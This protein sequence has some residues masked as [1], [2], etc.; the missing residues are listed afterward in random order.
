MKIKFR[1]NNFEEQ[2]KPLEKIKKMEDIDEIKSMISDIVEK[3]PT[4]LN[5]INNL[6]LYLT[7]QCSDKDIQLDKIKYILEHDLIDFPDNF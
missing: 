2:Y 7:G 1:R 4:L 5:T 6:D 3:S